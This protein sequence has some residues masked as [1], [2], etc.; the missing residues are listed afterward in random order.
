MNKSIMNEN[1]RFSDFKVMKSIAGYYLG[2]DIAEE[3]GLAML[4]IERE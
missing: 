1:V 2:R 3:D 4:I